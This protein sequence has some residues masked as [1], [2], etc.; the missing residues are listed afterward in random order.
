MISP[1]ITIEKYLMGRDKLFPTEY[2]EEIQKNAEYLLQQINAFLVDL[3]V[4]TAE[5]SS[6]FR[7]AA[8][9]A[10]TANAA[11]KSAHQTCEACDIKDDKYQTLANKVLARLDLLEKHG[12]YLE[13]PN[14]TKGKFSN[15]VH[16]QTRK[17]KSGNRVFKP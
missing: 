5:V 11:K 15:W 12:L 13:D 3:G 4:D 2:T 1:I 10:A 17:T 16:V 9:N 14:N 7:P 8:I 6:G